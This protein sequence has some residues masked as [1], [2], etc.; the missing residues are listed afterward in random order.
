MVLLLVHTPTLR[1]TALYQS[2]HWAGKRPPDLLHLKVTA[3]A[4][5]RDSLVLLATSW[6]T[7]LPG[8]VGYHVYPEPSAMARHMADEGHITVPRKE[9]LVDNSVWLPQDMKE[10]LIFYCTSWSLDAFITANIRTQEAHPQ[11]KHNLVSHS[12]LQTTAP[13]KCISVRRKWTFMRLCEKL[14]ERVGDTLE[15]WLLTGED[16]PPNDKAISG[17]SFGFY[18]LGQREVLLAANG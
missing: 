9:D 17:D 7:G 16:L 11:W 2:V 1:T 10:S 5:R 4:T 15:Q 13:I 14:Q 18:N 3:L 6:D 12:S 8:P